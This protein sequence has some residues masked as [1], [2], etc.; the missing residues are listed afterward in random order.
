[1]RICS[2]V[3]SVCVMANLVTL[4]RMLAM[5]VLCGVVRCLFVLLYPCA[6]PRSLRIVHP[7][8]S[9]SRLRESFVVRIVR[10]YIQSP[11]GYS[12]SLLCSSQM[13]CVRVQ[14]PMTLFPLFVL[15]ALISAFAICPDCRRKHR[16]F[17]FD[18][19]G[20]QRSTTSSTEH[21]NSD[22]NHLSSRT[23]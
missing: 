13:I 4:L 22:F 14:C 23:L 3:C 12:D 16:V 8:R 1:M 18:G 2:F 21:K 17:D 9:A 10:C 20:S 7:S 19:E 11:K 15:A 6:F 5:L